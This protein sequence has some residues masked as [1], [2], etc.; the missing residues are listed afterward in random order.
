MKKRIIAALLAAMVFTTSAVVSFA[1]NENGVSQEAGSL[2]EDVTTGT[3]EKEKE[4]AVDVDADIE[5]ELSSFIPEA[6]EEIKIAAADELIDLADKCKNDTWSANKKVVL[7]ENISL[8]G[9]NFAG[10]P[11]F[12]G[13]F[14]G[15][16]HTISEVN[17]KSGQSYV[18]FFT[19]IQKNAVVM[20][21]N[22]SG[23]IMPTGDTTI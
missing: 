23:S 18:G 12:G 10:I 21:L 6:M 13:V 8:V 17:I 1:E 16:G 11:S 20:N 22:I 7:T 3:Q 14:D 15:Q 4:D 19:H 5:E 9:K 2:P